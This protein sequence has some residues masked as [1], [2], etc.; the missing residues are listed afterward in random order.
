MVSS[1]DGPFA[2]GS[3]LKTIEGYAFVLT[4]LA[5]VD[6]PATLESIGEMAFFLCESLTT[7]KFNG[8]TCYGPN[9]N[10]AAD[11]FEGSSVDPKPA[12]CPSR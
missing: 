5:S 3:V 9:V 4:G 12:L 1:A 8:S 11:A 6:F 10:V 7:V 2:E